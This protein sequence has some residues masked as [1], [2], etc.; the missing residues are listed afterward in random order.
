MSGENDDK[1]IPVYW[2]NNNG[3]AGP[4]NETIE[5]VLDDIRSELQDWAIDDKPITLTITTGRMKRSE[6]ENLPEFEGY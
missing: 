4:C 1:V 3:M 6:Y 2:F 5:G